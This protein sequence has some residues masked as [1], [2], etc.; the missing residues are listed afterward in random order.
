[1]VALGE[2][3]FG[4]RQPHERLRIIGIGTHGGPQRLDVASRRGRLG[5][6]GAAED[7]NSVVDLLV[8]EDGVGFLDIQFA[9]APRDFPGG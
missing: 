1:V 4:G 2:N 8:G 3:P 6:S 5:D 9:A 7:D